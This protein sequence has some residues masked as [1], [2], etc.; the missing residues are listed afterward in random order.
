MNNPKPIL[1]TGAHRS[2]TTWVGKMLA[3]ASDVAYV[4]EPLNVWH[5]AGVY[6]APVERWYAYITEENE[7]AY[8]PAFRELLNFQYHTF[9]ELRSLRSFKDFLRMGRDLHI[10]F[11]AAL[12]GQRA[13]L[14]DPFAVFSS[15]WFAHRLN[16]EVVI[17]V[18]HP[19]AFAA[20]LKRL[21]WT[22]DFGN[23][24]DQPL[25]M[26]DHLA[27]QRAAMEAL[28]KDDVVGQA[29]LLWTLVYRF[30]DSLRAD[31]PQFRIVKHEDLSLDPVGGY[32]A[33][34]AALNLDFTPRVEQVIQTSSSSENPTKL[35]R[36]KTHSVKLDSR[37]NLANWKKNLAPDEIE[38]IR[39]TTRGVAE[40]FY[41]DADW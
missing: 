25:L 20:S 23:L 13:L 11:N 27:D 28:H 34:Y 3:A 7:S 1:V 26:R 30:V 14:K 12:R 31:F 18:R 32:R 6:R 21:N 37:A 8:L 39:K 9:L 10:F 24:L 17:T 33:L 2:G 41:A 35:A 4:S 36:N 40:R 29:A 38:R 5:R 15:V 22:F 19:A 16:C